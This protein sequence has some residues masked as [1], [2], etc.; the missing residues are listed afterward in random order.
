MIEPDRV[1]AETYRE[2]CVR[3]GHTLVPCASAQAA[4]LAADQSR[5]DVVIVELQLIQH[6]GIE[7][8][9]EFRSYPE[10][11]SIP[12]ILH[13]VV[14]PAEF[15]DNWQLL[16]QQL[17]VAQYLYKPQTSLRQLLAAID[18]VSLVA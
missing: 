11:Q 16:R 7:F 13:S 15:A 2:A 5:P 8:L 14:P 10:W 6:S 18:N 17:G 12:M 4:I 9:Y 1:L 3:A